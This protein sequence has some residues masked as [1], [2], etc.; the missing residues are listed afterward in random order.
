M[1]PKRKR[2]GKR[3][4]TLIPPIWKVSKANKGERAAGWGERASLANCVLER[5][6]KGTVITNGR[7]GEK[8]RQYIILT[9]N[10]HGLAKSSKP[11]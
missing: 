7:R 1:R 11:K 3:D 4:A 6:E 9:I 10:I 5:R 8:I 2:E